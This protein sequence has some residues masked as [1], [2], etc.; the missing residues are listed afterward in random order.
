MIPTVAHDSCGPPARKQE[1]RRW[2]HLFTLALAS[3]IKV[4]GN[5][6]ITLFNQKLG[7]SQEAIWKE[8]HEREGALSE[9]HNLER[10][11]MKSWRD[12]EESVGQ[13][14][15]RSQSKCKCYQK[16]RCVQQAMTAESRHRQEE[17]LMASTSGVN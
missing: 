13:E 2:L 8:T 5:T 1:A 10:Q 11:Q 3:S 12:V 15:Q 16:A 4:D 9:S 17:L 6:G 14:L 7:K